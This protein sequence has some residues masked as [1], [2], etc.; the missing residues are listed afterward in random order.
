MKKYLPLIFFISL[1]YVACHSGTRGVFAKKTPHEQ[2]AAKLDDKDLDKTPEGRAWLTAS[3]QALTQPEVVNLPY[4]LNG[5]FHA[6]KPRAVGLQFKVKAGQQLH[7]TLSK[8]EAANF[9]LYADLYEQEG[10][11]SKHLLA[12]D[13]NNSEFVFAA[14]QSGTYTLRIQPELSRT[15]SYKLLVAVG[16]SIEFPVSGAKARVGSVWGDARDGGRRSHEGIDI[17]A[18]KGTPAVAAADGRITSVKDGGIGGKTIWLRPEGKNYTLY[19]AHLDEQLVQEGQAVK[20]GD[21]VGTVGNTGNARTTPAHLHFGVYGY[22]G[23]IDPLPFVAK[24]LK[25][26]SAVPDR[27]L[28]GYLKLTKSLKN[29]SGQTIAAGSKLVPVGVSAKGYLTEMPDGRYMTIPFS[30]VQLLKEIPRPVQ[31][32]AGTPPV[33]N[34]RS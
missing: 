14:P 26:P 30:S 17:F 4:S 21:V 12:V 33:S 7:F 9:V 19:Y 34:R 27:G 24:G 25:T 16:P 29:E 23:A 11:S 8:E 13:T 15:G 20:K 10:G 32:I 1:F 6:D 28:K 31:S 22:G 18:P 3:Q 2:Y 5:Y